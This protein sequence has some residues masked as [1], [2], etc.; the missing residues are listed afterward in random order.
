M[1][2][3]YELLAVEGDLKGQAQRVIGQVKDLFQNG[4]GKFIG[5]LVTYQP[6]D[7]AGQQEP[8]QITDI[9]TTVSEQLDFLEKT[10]SSWLDVSI[11]K[12]VTN[13]ETAATIE[14][15]DQAF[16]LPAPALLN[17]EN[18]LEE[19]RAVYRVIPTND[20]TV[21]WDWD[22]DNGVY[23]SRPDV[24]IRTKKVMRSFVAYEHT[25]EHPAQVETYT[26]DTPIG[27]TTTYVRSGMIT[28][29]NKQRRLDRLESL[30]RTVKQARQRA[31]AV[32]AE[33]VKLGR[34]LF[35]YINGE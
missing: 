21:P 1:A 30:I 7:E 4:K 24:R 19:L 5:R 29:K 14:I 13:Q 15:G 3:L 10:F 25:P 8:P 32:D 2:K 28:P 16:D 22:A 17:L 20:V 9:A 35:D 23:V 12:E 27:Q 33:S 26:E 6:F 11:Q 18:K 34:H 31:N